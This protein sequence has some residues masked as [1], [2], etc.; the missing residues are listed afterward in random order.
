VVAFDDYLVAPLNGAYELAG[1]LLDDVRRYAVPLRRGTTLLANERRLREHVFPDRW[2]D[3]SFVVIDIALDGARISDA[4]ATNTAR[5]H[6][7]PLP[8]AAWRQPLTRG[9]EHLLLTGGARERLALLV[10]AWRPLVDGDVVEAT[11]PKV[12]WR[13]ARVTHPPAR[14]PR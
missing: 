8:L 10:P 12:M 4:R 6:G 3:A 5:L 11:V 14:R 1:F 7:A 13:F 9:D 2:F